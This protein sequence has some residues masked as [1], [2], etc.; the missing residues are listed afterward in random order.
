VEQRHI[1][2]LKALIARVRTIVGC[3]CAAHMVT[4]TMIGSHF[5]ID[6]T[7]SRSSGRAST[8]TI[9]GLC[10]SFVCFRASWPVDCSAWSRQQV[11]QGRLTLAAWQCR[12]LSRG[13]RTSPAGST[14]PPFVALRDP[15][16]PWYRGATAV[17][18]TALAADIDLSM[19]DRR[20]PER[21]LA[22]VVA[23]R[24]VATMCI[25]PA[26]ASSSSLHHAIRSGD[27]TLA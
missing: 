10:L 14:P 27:R 4:A 18:P 11:A 7:S 8:S 5:S 6:R 20:T 1:S 25:L 12:Q 26:G 2:K 21:V 13:L 23:E 19:R 3:D 16:L 22:D 24:G 9:E 15:N 17:W